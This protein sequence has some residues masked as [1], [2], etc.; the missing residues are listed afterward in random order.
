MEG[1]KVQKLTESNHTLVYV[2]CSAV[3]KSITAE[4]HQYGKTTLSTTSVFYSVNYHMEKMV[5][6]FKLIQ[7]TSKTSL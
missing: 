6:N 4:L 2:M 1:S 3:F 5:F 7:A